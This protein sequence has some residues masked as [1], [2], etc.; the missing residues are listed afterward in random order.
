[1]ARSTPAPVFLVHEPE[2]SSVLVHEGAEVT[3]FRYTRAANGDYNCTEPC[4]RSFRRI[5]DLIAHLRA[6]SALH[7]TRV[8]SCSRCGGLFEHKTTFK[9][10]ECV[11]R[12]GAVMET[13]T[14]IEQS[15]APQTS[16][17]NPSDEKSSDS[18][19]DKLDPLL[20]VLDPLLFVLDPRLFVENGTSFGASLAVRGTL[21]EIQSTANNDEELGGPTQSDDLLDKDELI[22]ESMA[23]TVPEYERWAAVS[24]FSPITR[25]MSS[26]SNNNDSSD[27]LNV[28][29]V[30][31]LEEPLAPIFPYEPMA[32]Q[33]IDGE[34]QIA[35]DQTTNFVFQLRSDPTV[36]GAPT[37]SSRGGMVNQRPLPSTPA[38]TSTGA[39]YPSCNITSH[40][41]AE[42]PVLQ[43]SAPQIPTTMTMNCM[44]GNGD[45]VTVPYTQDTNGHFHCAYCP[46]TLNTKP[47]LKRHHE[48]Q[49]LIKADYECIICHKIMS[50]RHTVKTHFPSCV[51]EHGNPNNHNWDDH[52]SCRAGRLRRLHQAGGG[53]AS[54]VAGPS[55]NARRALI[56]DISALMPNQQASAATLAAYDRVPRHTTEA[57]LAMAMSSALG[58][59]SDDKRDPGGLGIAL[60]NLVDELDDRGTVARMDALVAETAEDAGLDTATDDNTAN[61]EEDEDGD[62]Y[63]ML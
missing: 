59:I 26:S 53:N 45:V 4:P 3:V 35:D 38:V 36:H 28:Y 60:R 61:E 6:F 24:A 22:Y 11:P 15:V 54:A 2:H 42:L 44:D 58:L 29:P 13:S 63:M 57:L 46:I 30:H 16:A 10:H 37:Q 34:P 23:D 31:P 17:Q 33:S 19:E 52:P 49:H 43:T 62:D 14:A 7:L 5:F 32:T 27:N 47:F 18:F 39:A 9:K 40:S 1:M 51:R 21:E 56:G 12:G 50:R 8:F 48:E 55:L 25:S 20:S 41:G